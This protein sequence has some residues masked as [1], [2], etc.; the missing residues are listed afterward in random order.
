MLG[1]AP[2]PCAGFNGV[3][4]GSGGRDGLTTVLFDRLH[5]PFCPHDRGRG[6][7]GRFGDRSDRLAL[8]EGFADL[9]DTD[10]RYRRAAELHTFGFGSGLTSDDPAG[11]DRALKF[12]EHAQHLEEHPTGRRARVDGLLMQI[13]V[14]ASGL[15]VTQ[16]A[17]QI[18]QGAS[19]TV[20]RPCGH[21]VHFTPRHGRQEAVVARSPV[22]A[23]AAADALVSERVDNGPA[24]PSGD[25]VE[26]EELVLH[27]LG[28]RA[29]P[30]V[31][32]CAFQGRS[33]WS[34]MAG[35]DSHGWASSQQRTH[36]RA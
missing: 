7:A 35:P 6:D 1:R 23:L 32:G 34:L 13:E 16:E 21:D 31:E 24:R 8:G 4:S 29:D 28:V 18:G 2:R 25:L 19:Q 15:D 33:P 3:K 10:R 36:K 11:D 5:G 14:T 20:H 30:D 22:P 17:H 27:G 26:H 9:V 12:G